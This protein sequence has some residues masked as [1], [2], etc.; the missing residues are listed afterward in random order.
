MRLDGE[1]GLARVQYCRIPGGSIPITW[2][3]AL[4]P[5]TS[6]YR[7]FSRP[8]RDGDVRGYA[9]YLLEELLMSEE[10]YGNMKT[11]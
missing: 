8:A 5:P 10:L 2:T 3:N 1:Q 9:R 6:L 11:V 4:S 7:S